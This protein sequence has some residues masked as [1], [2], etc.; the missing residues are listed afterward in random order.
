MRVAAFASLIAASL[1]TT[2]AHADISGKANSLVAAI[3]DC[4]LITHAGKG[5]KTE[6]LCRDALAQGKPAFTLGRPNNAHL[7][8]LGTEPVQA[9]DPRPL[10]TEAA[11]HADSQA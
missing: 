7:V 1:W 2:V 11:G 6:G 10:L 4:I 8:K 9:A 3:A 5:S